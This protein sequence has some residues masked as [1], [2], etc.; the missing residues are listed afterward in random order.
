MHLLCTNVLGCRPFRVTGNL[1]PTR[2]VAVYTCVAWL[3][4][5]E[6]M[7]GL[8]TC[9]GA[10]TVVAV[11]PVERSPAT[12]TLLGGG[13]EMQLVPGF[14]THQCVGR[15]GQGYK[16]KDLLEGPEG[17]WDLGTH[18]LFNRYILTCRIAFQ[19][20]QIWAQRPGQ[21]WCLACWFK[22][23]SAPI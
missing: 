12:P 18:I 13:L 14:H 15:V 7:A 6:V 2:A 22:A 3:A 4:P 23:Y 1:V 5:R 8:G 16:D 9:T 21:W 19:E 17:H 11:F 10:G 20:Q